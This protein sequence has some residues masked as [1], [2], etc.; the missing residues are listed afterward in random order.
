M[1]RNPLPD[2]TRAFL[3]AD[4]AARARLRARLSELYASWGYQAVE[5]PALERYDPDHPRAAQSFK[6][7]DRDSGLL[8]LRSD[9]TPALARLVRRAWPQSA[10]PQGAER[11]LRLQVA[12]P[13]WQAIDPELAR[14]REFFQIGVEL[15]GTRHPRADAELIHLA[16]ESVRVVGLVPRVEVGAP[17]FVRALMDEADVPRGAREPLAE[18][19]DRKDPHDVA[20]MLKECGLRGPAADAL[21]VAPDLYGGIELLEEAQA[22][23]LGERSRAALGHLAGVLAEFED[24]SELILDLG[25]ARRLAY[26]TGV[27]FRAYTVDFGQPLLGGGRYDGALLPYAAGFSIGLERLESASAGSTGDAAPARVLSLDDEGARRLRAAGVPVV[28]AIA[29]DLDAARAEAG[30]AGIPWLL[31]PDGLEAIGAARDEAD[32]ER[33]RLAALASGDGAADA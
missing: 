17:G 3:P 32:G 30:W 13:V 10:D 22:L 28:R 12:G 8:A 6:L 18:A 29:S 19:I 23:P 16:R 5:V 20:A 14:T 1:T 25:M 26:Y 24:D 33:R 4:A 2:G 11:P 7:T 21:R 27:T 15:I 31:G 9:F